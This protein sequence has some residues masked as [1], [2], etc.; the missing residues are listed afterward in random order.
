MP[1]VKPFMN[2]LRFSSTA[3]AGIGTGAT[4]SILATAFTTDG[5][6]AATVFPTAP[7]YYNLYINGQIQTGDT[8]TVTTTSINIPDG[9]TLASAT[10]IV[11]EFV[12]N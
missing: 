12:V 9:D 7:A 8:S 11:V 5:G 1:I 6:T 3:G 2:S 10:P 4:Y